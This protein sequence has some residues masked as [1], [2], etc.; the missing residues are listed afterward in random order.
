MFSNYVSKWLMHFGEQFDYE[1]RFQQTW[2]TQGN[3]FEQSLISINKKKKSWLLEWQISSGIFIF[4]VANS[5]F[6]SNIQPWL[7][8]E[9]SVSLYQ[10]C[11]FK[12]ILMMSFILKSQWR[13]LH[14]CNATKTLLVLKKKSSSLALAV[15]QVINSKFIHLSWK[16]TS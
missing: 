14:N 2:I 7:Q 8:T 1:S 5:L 10:S 9:S 6:N 13:K 12:D 4:L 15:M 11:K 3:F 16:G